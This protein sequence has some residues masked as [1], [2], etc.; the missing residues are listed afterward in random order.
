MVDIRKFYADIQ[1]TLKHERADNPVY[2]SLRA[3]NA[4]LKV[5]MSYNPDLKTVMESFADYW[6][7]NYIENSE[8]LLEEPSTEKIDWLANILLLL[9]GELDSNQDFSAEDWSEIEDIINAEAEDIPIDVLT[10]I[11]STLVE[12]KKL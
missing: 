12:R 11:M 10:F 4:C 9:E 7:K 1:R 3:S 2:D 5:F 6:L 8:K